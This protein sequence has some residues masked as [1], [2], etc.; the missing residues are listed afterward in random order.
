M[1]WQRIFESMRGLA[2]EAER[3]AAR[4]DSL[5]NG[6]R[7]TLC[8]LADGEFLG[9]D[10]TAAMLARLTAAMSNSATRRAPRLGLGWVGAAAAFLLIFMPLFSP[11]MTAQVRHT[12][13]VTPVVRLASAGA[14]P[15]S[16]QATPAPVTAFAAQPTAWPA[17][18]LLAQTQTAYPKA[19]LAA[20][21]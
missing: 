16:R 3:E 17:M 10:E 5:E 15:L 1:F 11:W 12:S 13:T 18:D 20:R 9:A 6:L 14:S 8:A 7:Q 2:I 4:R 19:T 21:Q